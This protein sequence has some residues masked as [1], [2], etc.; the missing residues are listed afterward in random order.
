MSE[1]DYKILQHRAEEEKSSNRGDYI[2]HVLTITEAEVYIIAHCIL[3]RFY[4]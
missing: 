4:V 1:I 3:L 2:G